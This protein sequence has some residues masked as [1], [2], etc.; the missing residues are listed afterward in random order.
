MSEVDSGF[1]LAVIKGEDRGRTFPLHNREIH[2]GRKTSGTP[3]PHWIY[4]AEPTVSRHHATLMWDDAR[5]TY[6]IYHKSR[7]NPTLVNGKRIVNCPLGHDD[8]VQIGLLVFRLE[9]SAP[10]EVEDDFPL[11][12]G[13]RYESRMAPAPAAAEETSGDLQ[14]GL[15]LRVLEGPDRG[16][17]FPLASTVLFVGHRD[18][19]AEPHASHGILLNDEEIPREQIL[20]AWNEREQSYGVF[21]VESSTVPTRV[22]RYEAGEQQSVLLGPSMQMLLQPNDC[23]RFGRSVIRLELDTGDDLRAPSIYDTLPDSDESAPHDLAFEETPAGDRRRTNA[24]DHTR[25]RSIPSLP[26]PA[27]ESR[28]SDPPPAPPAAPPSAPSAASQPR[29]RA[30]P[31]GGWEPN[32]NDGGRKL[33]RRPG[34]FED[35]SLGSPTLGKRR[36]DADRRPESD[37]A[38]DNDDDASSAS[39]SSAH[40][41]PSSPAGGGLQF[42]AL[43]VT[44]VRNLPTR[45]SPDFPTASM[46]RPPAK[47]APGER[48]P[49]I[50]RSSTGPKPSFSD[51]TEGE[52]RPAAPPA[53]LLA[54]NVRVPIP[55]LPQSDE[56]ETIVRTRKRAETKG[57][58]H[59]DEHPTVSEDDE[60]GGFD[61]KDS[62]FSWRYRADYV[63]GFL[64]GPNRGQKIELLTRQLE[65]GREITVGAQGERLNEIEVDDP[66]IPNVLA[67][68]TYA[69]GRF[70]LL[71]E[72][73]DGLVAINHINVG[74]NEE[75]PI[76]TGD[77]I[78]LGESVLVFLERA[79][80]QVLSRFEL[81]VLNGIPEDQGRSHD[82]LRETVV[83][84][85]HRTS[86]VAL[87][88]P[89]VSRKHMS[90]TLRNGRFY[91]THLSTSNPTF[92]NGISL[93]RG[94]DR[95][96]N[97]GDKIQVSDHTTLLFRERSARS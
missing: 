96:L 66:S 24:P 39:S 51:D 23:I 55:P 97:D 30:L 86:D 21:P 11:I 67:K 28:P 64:E 89:E 8:V 61:F 27:T 4:F 35:E 48:A 33:V 87:A 29:N 50:G 71:N 19:G 85:R 31:S 43:D 60:I 75:M 63:L 62:T 94:R 93:P 20:L 91:L 70:S 46:E 26:V 69:S 81:F 1:Q 37:S 77:R 56:S 38:G 2:M 82:L 25:P 13:S 57:P 88:D 65:D 15:R 84:G 22:L 6:T 44:L 90:I 68:V 58:T 83:V 14:T 18:S 92:I 72:G 32:P 80:V 34:P 17:V 53:S 78:T 16:E 52:K 9:S 79:V 59:A 42:P 73:G 54:A 12:G 7:T 76:K 40:A 3:Q 45:T 74:A 95:L 47:P 49:A 10:R 5:R 41:S 36:L